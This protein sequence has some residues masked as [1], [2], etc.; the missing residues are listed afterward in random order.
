MTDAGK[1]LMTKFMSAIKYK[2]SDVEKLGQDILKK[3]TSGIKNSDQV[4]KAKT[5]CTDLADKC[6]KA[7][8]TKQSAFSGAGKYLVEGFSDGIDENTFKA[9]A[10]AKAMAKA[11]YEAAKDELDINSPSKVFRK[12]GGSVPEGFAQGIDRLSGLASKS[13]E[14]MARDSI[15]STS[16]AISHIADAINSDIDAQPT[17]RPVI[18]LTNVKSGANAI[19]GMLSGRRT[20]SLNTDSVGVVSASMANYQNGRNSDEIVSAI[21]ALRSDIA[22]TPRNI[23]SIN[24]ISY[25]DG[26]NVSTAIRDL[27]RAAK[28]ERRI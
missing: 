19:G 20:I 15:K 2:K 6:A 16:N 23:Y 24:G 14:E 1:N 8:K 9:K 25:N 4:S 26:S 22:N 21:K 5:A 12:M 27:V 28:I 10:S 17:I 11:A 13:S 18:D 3:F 7:I